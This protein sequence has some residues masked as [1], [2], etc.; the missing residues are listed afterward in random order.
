VA[1]SK[2]TTAKPPSTKVDPAL[3]E[4]FQRAK[5]EADRRRWVKDPVLW[6]QE[7]L[8]ETLWSKQREILESVRDNRLTSVPS[9]HGVGKALRDD[10]PVLTAN[11]WV[12]IG[13]LRVGDTVFD[14]D[15]APTAVTGVWAQGRRPMYRV[16][17][18]DG[19]CID[20]DEHHLW[21]V[22]QRPG[23]HKVEV[24][25]VLTTKQLAAEYKRRPQTWYRY[26]T[27]PPP[28]ISLPSI[29]VPFDAYTL[30]VILG[31][32]CLR[33]ATPTLTK[34]E[35]LDILDMMKCRLSKHVNNT[36]YGL[37]DT[38]PVMD[39]LGLMWKGSHEKFVPHVYLWNDEPTRRSILAGLLDT[40]GGMAGSSGIEFS[41]S[42]VHLADA[43][44]WLSRSLGGTVTR[45]HRKTNYRH[46]DGRQLP[47]KDSHRLYIRLPF[48]PF[49]CKR[50]HAAWSLPPSPVQ[51]PASSPATISSLTTLTSPRVSPA[52]GS[53]RTRRGKPSSSPPPPPGSRSRSSSGANSAARIPKVIS[54]GAPI[55]L[56]G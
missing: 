54:P 38:R 56:S 23:R 34:T 22:W 17:F 19:T 15:G 48:N 27:P 45:V 7:R 44:E 29:P 39:S 2:S 46:P 9:A 3:I 5:A 30:G 53:T 47:G 55:A 52:G 42:S 31:D 25:Q 28:V 50:K 40:D 24:E 10:T 49:R 14:R 13:D 37:L 16:T 32:G 6:V 41:S 43:V 20:A 12:E 33:A 18:N 21:Q 26:H 1:L 51:P 4:A 8:G 11:G 35:D 36:S